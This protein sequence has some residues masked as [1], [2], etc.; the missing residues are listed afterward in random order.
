MSPQFEFGKDFEFMHKIQA[1][2][3]AILGFYQL[4]LGRNKKH[5][6]LALSPLGAAGWAPRFGW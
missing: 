2:E 1:T 6:T 3:R 5:H 4:V